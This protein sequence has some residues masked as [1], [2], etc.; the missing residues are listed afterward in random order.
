MK[1]GILGGGIAGL[2]TA[3][4]L[5][6]HGIESTVFEG[7]DYVGGLARSFKWH[8]FTVDFAVHRLFTHDE[9]VLRQLLALVP[10]GR[11]IRRS[12][13][14]L[15]RK[16]L[17]DPINVVEVF[18]RYFPST[19][20]RIIWSYVTRVKHDEP[21]SFDEFVESH[22]GQELNRFFFQPYTEKLFGI[23]GS[24]IA[25]EWA[26]RKVR[27]SGP[28]QALRESSKKHFSYF[29]YPIRGGYGAIVDRLH[30]EVREQVVLNARVQGLAREGDRITAVLYQRGDQQCRDEFDEV[31][32]TL[33]LTVTGWMLG[34]DFPL[35][36]RKVDA[37]YL[38]VDRPYV[39]DNHWVY[40]MD[41][42]VSINRLTEFKNL[43]STDCPPD[44]TVLCAEVTNEYS[45]V[46]AQVVRDV[47]AAGLVK[48]DEILDTTS[49]RER[50]GYPVYDQ[51]YGS[52]V[53]YA[54]DELRAIRNLH[55]VGRSAEF[56]HKEV[57][58]N[59]AS[60]AELVNEL[61]INAPITTLERKRIPEM[62]RLP[63]VYAVVLTFNHVEDT[64]ECLESLSQMEIAEAELK[65]LVVD[66]GSSDDTPEIVSKQFPQVE[67]IETGRNLGVPW[68]YN[69]GF[70]H[71]LGA[72]ADYVLMLNNDTTVASDMLTPLLRAG[73]TDPQAGI[74]TPK[75]LY[76]DEPDRIWA[77]GG[78]YRTFPPAIVMLGRD[79]P[80]ASFKEP[81]YL[82]YALSCGLLIHR[83]AFEKAGLFDPGYFF[84]FDDWDFSQRVRAHGLHIQFVP[85]AR[86]W[87]K[88]SRSTRQHAEFFWRVWGES[89]TR[90]YRRHGRPAWL[91]LP[92][93]IG[94]IMARELFK[95]NAQMLKHFLSGVHTGLAKPLGPIPA[96]DSIPLPSAQYRAAEES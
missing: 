31:I 26:Q 18:Y 2:S 33:P 59:W 86:M 39:S 15:S 19:T 56:D 36:Y 83:R 78:R 9:N 41:G 30:N 55:L 29:Y 21:A 22:Y 32:S 52:V 54:R 25:V 5:K 85:E 45:D 60:A 14:Y 46:E 68:G 81:Q 67:I 65:I 34:Y 12:Q 87:H 4:Q 24:E 89:S 42:D 94:Y 47:V 79:K 91:S 51:D 76:Y 71:A 72:G 28:L 57:D 11:H 88:V 48:S 70:N 95:G 8:G 23:P 82:D 10:M 3:W 43:S 35:R 80:D 27:L 69:V 7:R 50:F 77:V 13:I 75:V 44:K 16:W 66:N 17:N 49:Y 1:V 84:Q 96:A 63:L 93:H 61:V 90:Y 92:I 20:A 74:L 73:E 64:V 40:F 53:D 38:L 6:Q 37:V 58:D 62:E